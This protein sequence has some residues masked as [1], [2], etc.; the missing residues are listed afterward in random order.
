MATKSFHLMGEDP[1]TA[2]Q[3]ELPASLDEQG[4]QHLIA[5]HFAI[6]DPSGMSIAHQKTQQ[7]LTF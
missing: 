4:L 7:K 3:I 2:Q 1:S 5:S 6:V